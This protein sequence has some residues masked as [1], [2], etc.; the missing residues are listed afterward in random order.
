MQ[1]DGASRIH[2]RP[3]AVRTLHPGE[4]D[5]RKILRDMR[6]VIVAYSGGVDSATLL[7]VAH[8]ELATDVLAVT[9]RSPSVA[10]GEVDAARA[11]ATQIGARHEVIDTREF[12]NPRYRENAAD[13]CF[14]C[15]D[16]LFSRLT[17]LALARGYA[18]V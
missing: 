8:E 10:R 2:S 17:E 3:D 6:R 18:Y 16:E 15:K 14:H 4:T 13:R 1:D 11:V 5:L 9:G 12:D 7:A